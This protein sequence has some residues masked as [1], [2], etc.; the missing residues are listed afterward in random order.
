M[1]IDGPTEATAAECI[2]LVKD[3]RQAH[4]AY[5][6]WREWD[7]KQSSADAPADAAGAEQFF[8]ELKSTNNKVCELFGV[9]TVRRD[10]IK[11]IAGPLM[12]FAALDR[13]AY[14]G[15]QLMIN[16]FTKDQY[17]APEYVAAL[18]DLDVI[19]RRLKTNQQNHKPG[20]EL[21]DPDAISKA[22]GIFS[23]NPDLSDREV[24]RRAGIPSSSKLTRSLQYQRVK[25][26]FVA[27]LPPRGTK[28]A[29]TR[30]V[31]ATD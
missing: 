14:P 10:A 20:D 15:L 21:D 27:N 16:G 18:N 2:K 12:D 30:E 29:K 31:E 22:I 25:Q 24:A 23:T 13:T 3:L 1:P 4:I 26:T 8:L 9:M 17:D 5:Q 7:D 11:S 19:R 6:E 28:N